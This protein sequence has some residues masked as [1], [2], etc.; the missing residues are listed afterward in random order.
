MTNRAAYPSRRSAST[1]SQ[2]KSR[3]VP[4]PSRTVCEAAQLGL[5][6]L[7]QDTTLSEDEAR[8]MAHTLMA[9][10]LEK[11][12]AVRADTGTSGGTDG[13]TSSGDGGMP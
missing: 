10:T 11:L 4:A 5:Y 12:A 9:V 2:A 6:Q 8:T 1:I 13:G 7:S 3:Q